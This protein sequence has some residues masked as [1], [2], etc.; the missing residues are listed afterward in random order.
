MAH[1]PLVSVQHWSA[2]CNRWPGHK[3]GGSLGK[4]PSG[5]EKLEPWFSSSPGGGGG[6]L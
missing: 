4:K 2:K 1:S 6:M 5:R 3:V